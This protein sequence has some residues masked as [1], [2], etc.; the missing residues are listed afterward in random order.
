MQPRTWQRHFVSEPR[1]LR[2]GD[3]F[4]LNE[5][6]R[7]VGRGLQTFRTLAVVLPLQLAVPQL[8]STLKWKFFASFC[9][10]EDVGARKM[11][12][13]ERS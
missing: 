3:Q 5:C 10:M 6:C 7:A 12:T 13:E 4:S 11:P 1:T 9:L 2:S 8:A